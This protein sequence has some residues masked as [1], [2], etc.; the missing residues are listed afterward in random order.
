MSKNYYVLPTSEIIL[1]S[2]ETSFLSVNV[3]TEKYT[4]DSVSPDFDE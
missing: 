2:M 4:K 3:T 1:I